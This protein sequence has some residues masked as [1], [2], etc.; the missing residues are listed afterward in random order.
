[1]IKTTHC[2][3]SLVFFVAGSWI[4]AYGRYQICDFTQGTAS[5]YDGKSKRYYCHLNNRAIIQAT[6]PY[7]VKD[8]RYR[9]YP[10]ESDN[11]MISMEI[12]I[13]DKKRFINHRIIS[14][15]DILGTVSESVLSWSNFGEATHLT[16][17]YPPDGILVAHEFYNFGFFC[18]RD[19]IDIHEHVRSFQNIK[20]QKATLT[21]TNKMGL[22]IPSGYIA[23]S[24]IGLVDIQLEEFSVTHG[25]GDVPTKLFVNAD[26][27]LQDFK[28]RYCIID[29]EKHPNVGFYC[30]GYLDPP[31]CFNEM[32]LSDSNIIGVAIEHLTTRERGD[33]IFI[34]IQREHLYAP[35]SASC[36]CLDPLTKQVSAEIVIIRGTEHTCN[37]A[38]MS[39]KNRIKPY[40]GDW[41]DV[42]LKPGDT[43]RITFP[44]DNCTKDPSTNNLLRNKNATVP[45]FSFFSPW[46]AKEFVY[47]ESKE[48]TSTGKRYYMLPIKNVFG[49]NVFE[50]DD[51]KRKDGIVTIKYNISDSK[52]TADPFRKL[53]Y[54][55]K[56]QCQNLPSENVTANISL[57]IVPTNA[58]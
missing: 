11:Y 6:C 34:N 26:V 45:C 3:W 18:M 13:V 40:I 56:Y 51:S 38:E 17:T 29:I 52:E 55:W 50:V 14:M 47:V 31:N 19:G 41:C 42:V 20:S 43:L 35:F 57:V 32:Y 37:I 53:R 7:Y 16:V 28:I 8:E 33:F 36:R 9:F 27:Y 54:K 23:A 21:L 30:T 4:L 25:C 5:L 15:S 2:V 22:N 44:P 49:D 24:P 39:I 10:A 1:M 46:D 48:E 58:T 12:Q